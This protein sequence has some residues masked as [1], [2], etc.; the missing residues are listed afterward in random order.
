MPSRL[1]SAL[2]VLGFLTGCASRPEQPQPAAGPAPGPPPAVLLTPIARVPA[3]LPAV[4]KPGEYFW[5]PNASPQ[6]PTV[7]VVSLPEQLAYVYRNGVA[8]GVTTVSTGKKGHRTPTG[9]FTIL[10]KKEKHTSNLYNAPM[11]Y[12]QRLTWTGIALHAGALPGYPASH[13]CIRLPKAF[14][15]E[16]FAATDRGTTVV[17]SDRNAFPDELVYPGLLAPAQGEA[18]VESLQEEL[19][20]GEFEW[21][22]ERS[23][24]GPVTVLLSRPDR[25]IYVFR[26]GVQIG[27]ARVIV[28]RPLEPLGDV[29]FTVLEGATGRPSPLV[30]GQPQLR[31]MAVGLSDDEQQI[32]REDIY[33]RVR[34]PAQFAGNVYRLLTPGTTVVITDLASTRETQSE[35]GFTVMA[36]DEK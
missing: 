32:L 36:S 3:N 33:R 27:K 20:E 34:V 10:Q 6:G 2:V 30:A 15:R 9:V 28:R 5:A 4:L 12:M 19:K 18:E 21:R 23:A 1:A 17:I 26:N 29:V 13:G 14:S 11:P 16:L 25:T 7:L 24:E 22:P 35:A 31:W 8:I